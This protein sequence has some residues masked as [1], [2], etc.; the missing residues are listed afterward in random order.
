MQQVAI[1]VSLIGQPAKLI[2]KNEE[3]FYVMIVSKWYF[4]LFKHSFSKWSPKWLLAAMNV[5]I[6]TLGWLV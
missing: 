2:G 6:S 5:A 3:H 4:E 1:V